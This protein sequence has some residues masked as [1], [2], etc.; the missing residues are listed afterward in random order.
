MISKE[1]AGASTRPI[2]LSILSRSES[3]GYAI[4]QDVRDLSDGIMEWK[5]GMLYPVLHRL[6]D[7]KLIESFWKTPDSG[8]PRKYYRLLAA[9]KEA[10]EAEKLAWLSVN[11][12]LSQLWGPERRLSLSY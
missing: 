2:L 5:E 1:L 8:R 3:Y 4:I 9:G 11:A 10:L 7:E 12:M 6:E